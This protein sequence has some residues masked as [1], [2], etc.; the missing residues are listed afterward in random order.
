MRHVKP[1]RHLRSLGYV[2]AVAAALSAMTPAAMA[3]DALKIAVARHG[4]WETAVPDLGQRAG[5]FKKQGLTLDLT[6]PQAEEIEPA[7]ISAS[8]DV[9][10]GVGIID[11]RPG[12]RIRLQEVRKPR[13][14]RNRETPPAAR[15]AVGPTP[16]P[17]TPRCLPVPQ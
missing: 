8:V 17:A 5:I 13:A 2:I 15:S 9:G 6:Y 3:E 7:M 10:V 4:A 11:I 1:T 14:F 16:P 12:L